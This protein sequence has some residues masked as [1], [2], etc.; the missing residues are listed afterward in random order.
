MGPWSKGELAYIPLVYQII[1][2]IDTFWDWLT[3]PFVYSISIWHLRERLMRGCLQLIIRK[4]FQTCHF[5]I[6]CRGWYIE[7]F[8]WR[9]IS[10]NAM[11]WCRQVWT[12]RLIKFN[13]RCQ[14]VK[15]NIENRNQKIRMG[16]NYFVQCENVRNNST[17]S[18]NIYNCLIYD[19]M[20]CLQWSSVASL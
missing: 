1:T 5:Q 8:P 10:R 20:F 11:A 6:H 12:K 17:Q 2:W 14:W 18:Y 19:A 9:W 15:F 4:S 16:D 7:N 3:G 13:T